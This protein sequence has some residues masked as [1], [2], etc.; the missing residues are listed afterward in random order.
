MRTGVRVGVIWTAAAV[1]A[2]AAWSA[3][4]VA[5]ASATAESGARFFDAVVLTLVVT[6]GGLVLSSHSGHGVGRVLLAGGTLWGVASLPLEVAVAQ[7][8][9]EP[10]S[11]PA[12]TLLAVS[13]AVRGF[14][15]TLLVAAL[16]LL[17][18]DGRLPSPRWRA[19]LHLAIAGAALHGM[20]VALGSVP[21]DLRVARYSNALAVPAGLQ[22]LLDL[23]RIAALLLILGCAAGGVVSIVRRWR[24]G[25]ALTRQRIGLFA[26]AGAVQLALVPLLFLFILTPGSAVVYTAIAAV[27]PV[28]I[29]VGV[30]Q[31]RLYDLPRLLNRTLVYLALSGLVIAMYVLVVAGVGAALNATGGG[32]LPLLAT[33]LVAAAILPLREAVQRGVNRLT[34]GA[35]EEP[36]AVVTDLGRQLAD[37]G[38]PG[39]ALPSAI[40]GVAEALRLPYV[41]VRGVDGLLVE[42]GKATGAET[43]VPLVHEGNEVGRLVVGLGGLRRARDSR[44]IHDLARQV[45]PTVHAA[46][47]TTELRRSRDRLVLAREEERRRLRRDLHDGL[48]PVLAAASLKVDTA[49]NVLRDDPRA[50]PLLLEARAVVQG[51]VSDVRRVVEGLRPPAL[52]DLGLTGA[53]ARL[54]SDLSGPADVRLEAGGLGGVDGRLPA[55]VEVAAYRIVQEALTNVVRHSRAST[56]VVRL[57]AE[58]DALHVEVVDDGCGLRIPG[59]PAGS[60]NGRRG[61]GMDSMRERA[62]EVGGTIRISGCREGGT[63]VA[64]AL[65]IAAT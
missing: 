28:A 60:P 24:R 63:V 6:V 47:L 4:F 13:F 5:R 36:Y 2:G 21:P 34:Y 17:F 30:A 64:A 52:D 3:A 39:G 59:S 33:G 29:A 38:A 42:H 35:W 57:H 50:E 51:A 40:T 65:P 53:V 20:S 45:A 18:P 62:E 11:T 44:L 8:Q 26:I 56:A 25:D 46:A 27:L 41:A 10:G 7:V 15:W 37:A 31:R 54:A 22:L 16:P 49:R 61:T 43:D 1:A 58:A 48:G 9:E 23:L 12:G 14:G 19:G 55:A 32:W